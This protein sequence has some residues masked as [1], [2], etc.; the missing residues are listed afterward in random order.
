MC[1]GGA[2]SR[3]S[4]TGTS[5]LGRKTPIRPPK[6]AR[7]LV[8]FFREAP[9]LE[10]P[11]HGG[12]CSSGNKALRRSNSSKTELVL[13]VTPLRFPVVVHT[14][15]RQSSTSRVDLASASA[16]GVVSGS[17]SDAKSATSDAKNWSNTKIAKSKSDFSGQRCCRPWALRKTTP[18]SGSPSASTVHM[19]VTHT[20]LSVSTHCRA[21]VFVRRPAFFFKRF[22]SLAT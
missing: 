15:T 1:E 21:T 2:F 11:Q 18:G 7:H 22:V 17:H 6:R 3:I 19:T 9:R 16:S 12:R 4:S 13:G 8:A 5:S 20:M 14:E 10:M